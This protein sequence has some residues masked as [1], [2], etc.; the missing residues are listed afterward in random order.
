MPQQQKCEKCSVK[1]Y[2]ILLNKVVLQDH[3]KNKREVTTVCD[4]CLNEYSRDE[5][6]EWWSNH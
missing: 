1:K 5:K 3:T 2:P 6:F 4:E